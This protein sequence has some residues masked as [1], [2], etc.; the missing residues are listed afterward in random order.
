LLSNFERSNVVYID[1]QDR[2]RAGWFGYEYNI[3]KPERDV[4]ILWILLT[5]ILQFTSFFMT[6]S[7]YSANTHSTRNRNRSFSE[8]SFFRND[9]MI[10]YSVSEQVPRVNLQ[11][12]KV[13][14]KST[15]IL[16]MNE[17]LLLFLLEILQ[18][19]IDISL[20]SQPSI[21]DYNE[22]LQLILE[23]MQN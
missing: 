15:Q 10:D 12:L 17:V 20:N 22:N 1:I 16:T 2:D 21:I 6:H 3:N 13:M 19:K 5:Y 8:R 7:T 11:K 18:T 14:N 9:A 4:G 23:L